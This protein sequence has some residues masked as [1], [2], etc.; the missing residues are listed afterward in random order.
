MS[1]PLPTATLASLSPDTHI[2]P[3]DIAEQLGRRLDRQG[4]G[5]EATRSAAGRE[6]ARAKRAAADPRE[7]P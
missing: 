6:A 4:K 5:A 2:L 7:R 1:A 3:P